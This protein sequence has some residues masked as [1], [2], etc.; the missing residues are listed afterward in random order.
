MHGSRG[1]AEPAGPQLRS[2]PAIIAGIAQALLPPNPRVDW[3]RWVSDYA[4]IREAIAKTWPDIFHDFNARM[5]TPG[6]FHRPLGAR[7][8]QWKTETGKA[9]FVIPSSLDA[10]PDMQREKGD[11][12][13]LMTIRSNDQFNTT[14][15]G[16]E[17]RFR[18]VHGTRQV[19]FMAPADIEHHGL[20]PGDLV[21]V[22]TVADDFVREVSNLRVTPYEIP[23]GCAAAYYPECNPLIP[24]WHHADREPGSG[25]EVNSRSCS[26]GG[27]RPLTG[28]DVING[29]W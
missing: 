12:L 5:F 19:I 22:A 4:S 11:V 15:Y 6:G 25:C 9:N 17:D 21:T 8:R 14:I 20:Q 29:R 3:S 1:F 16:F 13:R 18:G 24:L 2:E 26:Q 23:P 7:H 27:A 28:A 10:D